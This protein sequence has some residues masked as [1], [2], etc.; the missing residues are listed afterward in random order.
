MFIQGMHGLGDNVHQRAIIRQLARHH[1]EIWLETS[2]PQL[3]HD[4]PV[5]CVARPTSLR[6][7]T[8]NAKRHQDSFCTHSAPVDLSITYSPDQVRRSGS[9][10][11]AMAET[12]RVRGNL[13]FRFPVPTEWVEK[14]RSFIGDVTHPILL[15]RP[16]VERKEWG[17]CRNRNP[18]PQAYVELF[19]LVRRGYYV[20]SVADLSPGE[21]WV[22][23]GSVSPDMEFHHGE[24]HFE[25]LAGL[26][27]LASLV[28]ASP[29]FAIPLAQAIETPVVGVFG[30][31]ESPRS[32]AGGERF[33]PHLW[34]A[35]PNPCECFSHTHRCEKKIDVSQWVTT[36]QE[37][38][39]AVASG[40][41][42]SSPD[43]LDRPT[44]AVHESGRAGNPV[45]SVS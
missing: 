11:M 8:K 43:R 26:F 31:Y 24:L 7:Q 3:Y 35:P 1:A 13:D 16:L 27:K 4:L 34:I 41:H 18:D 25:V 2:W 23:S 44:E 28:W 33:A 29:G 12:A 30:G 36:L 38:S 9:V 5:R 42:R 6:T 39:H 22:V 19:N 21:E 32:F 10:L 20:I 40:F 14:A 15:Y 17:G 45:S 37:F